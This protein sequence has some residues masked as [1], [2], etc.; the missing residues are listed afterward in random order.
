LFR[1]ASEKLKLAALA[2]IIAALIGLFIFANSNT[3]QI[4]EAETCA[5]YA[6]SAVADYKRMME[7]P[8]CQE[9]TTLFIFRWQSTYQSYLTWCNSVPSSLANWE[10]EERDAHLKKCGAR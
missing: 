3:G 6:D 1:I 4:P 8:K 7:I 9:N 10:R 2:M 5:H